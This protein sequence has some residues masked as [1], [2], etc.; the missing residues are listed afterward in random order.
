MTVD[1]EDKHARPSAATDARMLALALLERRAAGATVCPSEVARALVA[2]GGD[3]GTGGEWR[4]VMPEVHAAVDQLLA[5][6]V[7][8]LSWKGRVLATRSGPYRIGH[9]GK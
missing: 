2:H 9:S 1:A 8:Q 4:D 3:L 7:V 5:E 6:G